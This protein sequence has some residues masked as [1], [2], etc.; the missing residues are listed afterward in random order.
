MNCRKCGATIADKAIVCYR[1][2]TATTEAKFKAPPPRKPRSALN[3]VS[4]V[5]ALV[6]LALFA[7]Y[8]QRLMTVGAPSALR[9]LIVI[10][11]VA[12]VVLRLLAR[13]T[14]R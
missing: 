6:I 8:M 3:L 4:S 13:R 1:C 5:L 2:G 7:L 14:T 12:I 9:W 10:L 11:A